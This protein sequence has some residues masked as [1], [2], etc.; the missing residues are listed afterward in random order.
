MVTD[1][2]SQNTNNSVEDAS[3]VLYPSPESLGAH[4]RAKGFVQQDREGKTE[5]KAK[6]RWCA[7][8][9]HRAQGYEGVG[10]CQAKVEVAR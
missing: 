10:H 7:F 1:R 9:P 5:N 8:R 2:L 6:A 4:K 3:T